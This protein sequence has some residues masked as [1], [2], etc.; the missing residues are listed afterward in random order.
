MTYS[1]DD[2]TTYFYQCPTMYFQKYP[3]VYSYKAQRLSNPGIILYYYDTV[4]TA[5]CPGHVYTFAFYV[6]YD[7]VLCQN[8]AII[9]D[10][11][12]NQKFKNII[13]SDNNYDHASTELLYIIDTTL[14]TWKYLSYFF[15]QITKYQGVY[16]VL[17]QTFMF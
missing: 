2:P 13:T 11:F 12:I 3:T 10:S 14:K 4:N 8:Y 5:K 1:Y 9:W 7:E 15:F 16:S 17:S 6:L